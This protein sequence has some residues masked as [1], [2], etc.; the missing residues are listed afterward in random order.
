MVVAAACVLPFGVAQAG[1]SLLTPGILPYALAVAVLSS[2]LPYSLEMFAL[3]RLPAKTFGT[4]MSL[5]P[6]IGAL[7]GFVILRERLAPSQWLAIGAVMAASIG[8]TATAARAGSA[9][10]LSDPPLVGVDDEPR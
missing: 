8:A 2:A 9:P 1:A 6:A 4:L 7:S 3:E 10:H 5:E